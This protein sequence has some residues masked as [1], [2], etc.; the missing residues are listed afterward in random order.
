[1]KI[2]EDLDNHQF[3][4]EVVDSYFNL[5][6]LDQQEKSFINRVVYGTVEN[7]LKLDF[8]INQFSKIETTKMKKTIITVLRM[9]VY[10]LLYMD[11]V[12]D[13]AV[14]DEAVKL[15]KKRKMVNLSGFVNG[16]L[17]TIGRNLSQI[18]YP[19]ENESNF[20]SVMYSFPQWLVDELLLQYD[21]AIVK[22]I[23]ENSLKTPHLCIRHNPLKG[24][25]E[26]MIHSI[27][28][29]QVKMSK[30]HFLPYAFYLD[31]VSSLRKLEA[32]N[33]GLFQVQD[34]S[35]MLIGEVCKPKETD[36]V[37]DICAAPGG[38]TTHLAELMNNKGK[39]I[40][41]DISEK[42][43]TLIE[44]NLKR[45]G[46]IN[47]TLQ[48]HDA[49][50]LDQTLLEKLDIVLA[51]VPCSGLGIIQKKPDIKYNVTSEGIKSLIK[52]Q[53]SI[54]DVACQ[55]VKKGGI[56]IYSTCTINQHENEE[57]VAWFLNNH[58][59]FE[60]ISLNFDFTNQ[61]KTE[62]NRH[63]LQLLPIN[64][65]SDGFFIAKLQRMK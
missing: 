64:E 46:I 25:I 18:K 21:T 38:K 12:P 59:N 40:S 49:T 51:D 62:N 55:Y 10:Q 41:R 13:S 50:V 22:E 3:I 53:R 14:I 52:I 9:S 16:V 27:E 42:K 31:G 36:L 57:N 45:L 54:I 1:M 20:L 37:L 44:E 61:Y 47:V 65:Q 30:G 43:L 48:S 58:P 17:R 11:S 60:V 26:E 24:S 56:L 7:R 8:I 6:E 35:S 32:F 28:K 2:L 5:Y 15:V 33:K 63:Y 23:C 4:Q 34:E 19:A 29:E 39:I